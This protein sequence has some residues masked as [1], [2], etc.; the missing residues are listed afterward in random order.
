[1]RRVWKAWVCYKAEQKR[2]ARIAAYTRNK[3]HR[4]KLR[5]LFESWRG[6]SHE[7][8]KGR[9]GQEEASFRADLEGKML[10]QYST[11]VDA[12]LLYVAELED[13]IKEE[14]DARER[15]AIVYDQSV[16]TGFEKLNEETRVLSANPLLHEVVVSRLDNE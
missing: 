15:L 14:Q 13:K 16:N 2:K 7:L 10:V 9:I 8:F 12:M 4:A 11:K 1:M 6:V 3:L 5:R